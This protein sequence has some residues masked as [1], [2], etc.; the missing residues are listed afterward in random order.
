MSQSKMELGGFIDKLNGDLA[1]EYRS[2][3]QYVQHISS[4]KGARYRQLVSDLKAH[5][6]QELEHAMIL[7]GQIDFL[8]G[9]PNTDVP[10][11]EPETEPGRAL[12]QDLSLEE[13]QLGRYRERIE[14]ANELGLPD[15]AEALVP[16]LSQTQHHVH[17]LRSALGVSRDTLQ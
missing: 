7:A 9:V 17:D 2:I 11:V 3:I 8:G 4:I 13:R 12:E 6:S 14:E 1:S 10:A 16:L 5:V 15:V